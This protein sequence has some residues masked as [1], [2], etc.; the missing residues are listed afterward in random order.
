[1]NWPCQG[2]CIDAG[3]LWRNGAALFF[4]S[5]A[6]WHYDV[7][8][9]K[10]D[11]AE[12]SYPRP[13]PFPGL[14]QAWSRGYDTAFNGDD[15]KVYWLKGHEY[16]RIDVAGAKVDAGPLPISSRWPALPQAWTAGINAAV[17][18][19]NGK[20]IFFKGQEAL[21]YDLSNDQV[22]PPRPI[23]DTL[24]GLP[25]AWSNTIDSAINWGNG[26]A[27]LF[28]GHQYVRYDIVSDRVDAGYPRPIASDWPGLMR[29]IEWTSRSAS[30]LPDDA[31]NVGRAADGKP[32]FL[33]AVIVGNA[34]Y[35]GKT[36]SA[37]SSCTY[38]DGQREL[39]SG[40][41]AVAA[42][43][44]SL[45]WTATSS[46]QRD[47]L[48]ST[49]ATPDG[50][51]YYLCRAGFA[52]GIY[53]GRIEDLSGACTITHDGRT[54]SSNGQCRGCHGAHSRQ[55]SR[56]TGPCQDIKPASR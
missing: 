33:C 52:N 42:T 1:M 50:R 12:G 4:K 15:G 3:V 23:A 14:P 7:D 35:P 49:G 25:D 53:P 16:V 8:R 38:A 2:R 34:I 51:S 24:R 56:N 44:L 54:E 5:N 32:F 30:K 6:F 39:A 43:R 10:V 27:Y 29:L 19:G 21:R 17:N 20:I 22:D 55:S 41:Y 11:D 13:I 47:K 36:Q 18:W 45:A 46:A 31:I 37:D 28:K 48:I 26:K 9:N 40:M